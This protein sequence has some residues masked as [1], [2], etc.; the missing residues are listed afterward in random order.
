MESMQKFVCSLATTD[1]RTGQMSIKNIIEPLIQLPLSVPDKSEYARVQE[2]GYFEVREQIS[3][4]DIRDVLAED[5]YR[6]LTI[7]GWI[8][9]SEDQRCSPAWYILQETD[10]RYVVGYSEKGV[11]SDEEKYDNALD[12]CASFIKHHI[13]SMYELIYLPERRKKHNDPQSKAGRSLLIRK[14]SKDRMSGSRRL[15]PGSGPG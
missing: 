13:D 3:V 4:S 1:G 8:Q 15:D 11:H 6:D 9:H 2:T 7:K 10:A 5:P 14:Q 12:A